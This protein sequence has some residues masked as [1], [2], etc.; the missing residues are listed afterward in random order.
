VSRVRSDGADGEKPMKHALIALALLSSG[1]CSILPGGDPSAF[2]EEAMS[3][4]RYRIA[5]VAP[6]G[7]TSRQVSDRVMARAAQVTLDKGQEWF[8]IA[9]KIDGKTDGKSAQTL[10]IIMGKGESLA[11]GPRKYDAKET[12]AA[13]RDRVG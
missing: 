3:G 11:G 1:A 6:D 9:S 8:E 5:Y 4:A 7:V 13:L 10:I 2:T 12:L